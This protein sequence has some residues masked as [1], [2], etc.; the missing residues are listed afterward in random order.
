MANDDLP[1]PPSEPGFK[2]ET[3]VVQDGYAYWRSKVENGKLPARTAIDPTEIPRL[4]PCIVILDVIDGPELDFRY[5]LI[6]TK[7]AENLYRDYTGTLMSDIETQRAPSQIW[8]N[9]KSVVDSGEPLLPYTEYAG[10]N[11]GFRRAEDVILPLS[12]DGETVD[13]L[14]VF[15]EYI[16]RD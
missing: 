2:F 4:L 8:Q 7:V 16:P 1:G 6:G 15:V 10:P 13:N 14:L 12:S 3:R 11:K 5:R 9:C